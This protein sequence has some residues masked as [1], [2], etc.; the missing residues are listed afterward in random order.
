MRKPAFAS[1]HAAC[2]RYGR[3][4]RAPRPCGATHRVP[5]VDSV[6]H[7]NDAV[8]RA[9]ARKTAKRLHIRAS[10]DITRAACGPRAPKRRRA[11]RETS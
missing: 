8:P 10:S 4:D 11:S 5:P 1:A 9:E 7:R 2:L 6:P 3:A